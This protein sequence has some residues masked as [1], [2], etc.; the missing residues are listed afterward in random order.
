[1]KKMLLFLFL[2]CSALVI[3]AQT[4]TTVIPV[5]I[6]METSDEVKAYYF[7]EANIL[8]VNKA[9]A[10]EN[11]G[12]ITKTV[13]EGNVVF[14][15]TQSNLSDKEMLNLIKNNQNSERKTNLIIIF[16]IVIGFVCFIF[17]VKWYTSH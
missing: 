1:M 13:I 2:V 8:H 7:D 17:W 5:P 11:V 10:Y 15:H 12:D 6:L 14:I 9:S 16:S 3:F 4:S